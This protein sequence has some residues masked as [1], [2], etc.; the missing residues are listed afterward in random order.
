MIGIRIGDRDR[1]RVRVWV[2]V[3]A[4]PWHMRFFICTIPSFLC[5][6]QYRSTVEL[7]ELALGWP[8]SGLRVP[9]MGLML[10]PGSGVGK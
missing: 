1:D 5:S 8:Y 4:S 6:W 2:R 10:G 3:V 9:A 7:E